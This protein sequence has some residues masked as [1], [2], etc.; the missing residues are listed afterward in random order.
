MKAIKFTYVLVFALALTVAATGCRKS[1]V[2]VI[3]LKGQRAG[4]PGGGEPARLP[5]EAPR[6]D[7]RDYPEG[8]VPMSPDLT[9]DLESRFNFDRETLAA[10]TVYFDFDS[11]AIKSSE[12]SRVGAV[13]TYMQATAGVSLLVEGHCD[14]RGTE[15][16]NDALGERRALAVRE[17]LVL[18]FGVDG[19]RVTT[20]TYG[21]HR[22]ADPGKTEAA[23]AKNRRG[24]FVVL[25]PK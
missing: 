11:S 20:R 8:F 16:Y 13:A 3:D 9:G 15:G 24:E 12:R 18:Q 14:E 25:R 2:G 7:P 22:P 1:P 5:E 6:L 10:Q 19:N 17:M 23:Y 21:E 4:S